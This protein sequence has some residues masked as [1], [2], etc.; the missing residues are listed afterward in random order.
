MW[1]PSCRSVS[2]SVHLLQ[3]LKYTISDRLGHVWL[4]KSRLQNKP[5]HVAGFF[6]LAAAIVTRS[7]N[8]NNSLQIHLRPRNFVFLNKF[9]FESYLPNVSAIQDLRFV[10]LMPFPWRIRWRRSPVMSTETESVAFFFSSCHTPTP[11]C[12]EV[13]HSYW[14]EWDSVKCLFGRSATRWLEVISACP[15]RE[16]AAFVFLSPCFSIQSHSLALGCLV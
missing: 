1:F 9:P 15:Y 4:F 3:E 13:T 16:E 7:H 14:C 6:P 10:V 8:N 12:A 2:C 5:W 11:F